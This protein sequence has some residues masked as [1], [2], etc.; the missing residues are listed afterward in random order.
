LGTLTSNGFATRTGEQIL[1]QSSN[2]ETIE[3]VSSI[4]IESL[5]FV[6]MVDSVG[7]ANLYQLSTANGSMESVGYYKTVPSGVSSV[8]YST[9]VLL[10][11]SSCKSSK[12]TCI[13]IAQVFAASSNT[14][15]RSCDSA[16]QLWELP[17]DQIATAA[18]S[19][20]PAEVGPSFCLQ[21]GILIESASIALTFSNCERF[22]ERPCILLRRSCDLRG[23]CGFQAAVPSIRNFSTSE[24]IRRRPSSFGA[25]HYRRWR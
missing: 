10:G 15:S 12:G 21:T 18:R 6:Q 25:A 16:I 24:D 3:S 4:S 17:V 14:Q 8:R 5:A 23:V 13:I 11:T 7:L 19:L 22:G 2:L 1:P 9:S 20:V